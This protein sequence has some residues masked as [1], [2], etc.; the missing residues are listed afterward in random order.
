MKQAWAKL[1]CWWFSMKSLLNI[2]YERSIE[3]SGFCTWIGNEFSSMT[4][5]LDSSDRDHYGRTVFER[6][7]D[8]SSIWASCHKFEKRRPTNQ[9]L[10]SWW[11]MEVV[12]WMSH[13]WHLVHFHL[14]TLR[15][16]TCFHKWLLF[17]GCAFSLVR[18]NSWLKGSHLHRVSGSEDIVNWQNCI[19]FINILYVASLTPSL[20][21]RV[22]DA[23]IILR[24]PP[25]E[26][27]LKKDRSFTPLKF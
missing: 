1:L 6:S 3:A 15:W 5:I 8:S 27:S 4:V 19:E 17:G 22:R 23:S 14:L 12:S 18:P 2:K 20:N 7:S 11:C 21:R 25:K 9:G 26:R 24:Y 16:F 13:K 10:R